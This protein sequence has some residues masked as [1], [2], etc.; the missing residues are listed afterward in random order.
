M[1]WTDRSSGGYGEDPYG[2]AG[3]TY[4]HGYGPGGGATTSTPVAPWAPGRL[5][6]GPYPT[7]DARTEETD[8]HGTETHVLATGPAPATT[9]LDAPHGDVLTMPLP[10]LRTPGAPTAGAQTPRSESVRPVF[11][12][13]SGRRQ[14]RVRRAARLLVIPAGGYIALLVSAVLG[15]PSLNAPFVPQPDSPHRSTPHAS[16][17]DASP[18][19]GHSARR[20]ESAVARENSRSTAA[21]QKSSP[22]GRPT[23]SATSAATP[24][25]TTE[26]TT[27]PT[28]VTSPTSSPTSPASPA[29]PAAP[30]RRTS[31]GRA[32]GTSHKPVK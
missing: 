27:A 26:P 2:G 30:A 16:V 10:G 25:Q 11:V 24:G 13:S 28:S 6:Q 23:A 3:H 7:A 29:T 17:P 21:R 12:D 1:Q 19:T 18:G 31:K 8:L 15:G 4:S 14:R 20:P 22:T 9:A 32:L 5:A